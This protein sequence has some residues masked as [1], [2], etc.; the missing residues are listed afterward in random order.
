MVVASEFLAAH[1]AR[2]EANSLEMGVASEYLTAHASEF[3]AAH[4]VRLEANS[5]EMVVASEC[6]AAHFVR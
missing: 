2:L 1:F 4:F 6:L 3:L 5:L